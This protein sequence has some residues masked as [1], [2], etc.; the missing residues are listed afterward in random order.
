MW[1]G[2]FSYRVIS[3][4]LRDE[5]PNYEASMQKLFTDQLVQGVARTAMKTLGLYA[6][7]WDSDDERTV[8]RAKWSRGYLGRSRRRSAAARPRSSA[9]SSRR[10]V[11]GCRAARRRPCGTRPS[12]V[13]RLPRGAAQR[14][15][16]HP[17]W[18]RR[19]R[20]PG[21]ATRDAG[22][23]RLLRG[24]LPHLDHRRRVKYRLLQDAPQVTLVVD[25]APTYRTVVVSGRRRFLDDD[26]S[27]L[28]LRARLYAKY[29]RDFGQPR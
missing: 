6:P 21:R 27:L 28:D 4:Q 20:V 11:W 5:V 26:A 16:L 24:P 15:P 18:R 3:M 13:R 29:R 22:V 9:T 1:R 7:L 25:D 23:V 14:H 12:R 19:G 2:L 10:A 17:A 8:L